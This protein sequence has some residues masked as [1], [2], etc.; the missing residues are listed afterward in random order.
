MNRIQQIITQK[1]NSELR[2][3]DETLSKIGVNIKTWN[4][5]VKNKKDPEL[6]QLPAIAD[7]LQCTVAELIETRT[8]AANV[9]Q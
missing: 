5:W 8:P 1:G 3:S 9:N 7:F 4:K 2:P 6:D